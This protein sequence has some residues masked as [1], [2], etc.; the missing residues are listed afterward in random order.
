MQHLVRA[1]SLLNIAISAVGRG[2]E[3]LRKSDMKHPVRTDILNG[4]IKGGV[5][6]EAAPGPGQQSAPLSLS[7]SAVGTFFGKQPDFVLRLARF[8]RPFIVPVPSG[9]SSSAQRPA[10]TQAASPLSASRREVFLV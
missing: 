5:Q 7:Q 6:M 3:S 2:T 1:N 8:M 9:H 4:A 10:P